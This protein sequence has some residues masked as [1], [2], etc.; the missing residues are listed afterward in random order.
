MV[1]FDDIQIAV[2]NSPSLTTVRQPLQKMG[3]TAARTLLNRIDDPETYV[4][5]IQI[6][7]ELVVRN[8][9][10]RVPESTTSHIPGWQSVPRFR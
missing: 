6:E 3:E 5:E 8:S 2:H 10:A 7:P 9:T 1:G 4:A